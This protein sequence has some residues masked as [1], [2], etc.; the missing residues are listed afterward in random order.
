MNGALCWF[1][2]ELMPAHA[3]RVPVLDHG[4][5]CGDGVFEGIRFYHGRA[6]RLDAHLA[7]LYRSAR[8]IRLTIPSTV[9]RSQ[10]QCM[11][12]LPRSACLTVTCGS[13]SHAAPASSA[14]TRRRA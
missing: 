8:A 11:T 6:Y 4:L 12:P 7:R 10:R 3:A 13:W 5:L 1:N 14:S 2:G 9:R